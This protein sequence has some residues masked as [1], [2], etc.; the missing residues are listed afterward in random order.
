M[1][2]PGTVP[3]PAATD[4]EA[5]AR[6]AFANE[7]WTL[8]GRPLAWPLR[9]D[10]LC[11]LLRSKG[12]A[13]GVA[14]VA[15]FVARRMLVPPAD[16]SLWGALDAIRLGGLLESQ[17]AWAPNG[18][19]RPKLPEAWRYLF[20]AREAGTAGVADL[21]R[22]VTADGPRLTPRGLLILLC[23]ADNRELR[24]A[25]SAQLMAGLQVEHGILI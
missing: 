19:H 14:D 16:G 2:I 11:A 3:P 25:V 23:H 12:Y 22:E 5:V 17:R 10:K 20:D 4:P 18:P 24:E 7:G 15:D 21:W 8:D 1:L 6:A 9:L 13:V